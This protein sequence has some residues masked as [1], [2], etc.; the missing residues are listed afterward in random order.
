MRR[1][2]KQRIRNIS[3]SDII[4]CIHGGEI[5]EQYLNG[6][7]LQRTEKILEKFKTNMFIVMGIAEKAI[8][9]FA[10]IPFLKCFQ[11]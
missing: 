5:I 9:F 3:I 4:S 10:A 2:L 6:V 11:K 8:L 1:M 7:N